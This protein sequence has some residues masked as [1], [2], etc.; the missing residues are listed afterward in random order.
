[1]VPTSENEVVCVTGNI[2]QLGNWNP[3]NVVSLQK[4]NV[5]EI[6]Y[7]DLW[8][9]ILDV[10]A[11]T[12]VQ[13]RFCVTAPLETA[14][15]EKKY[16]IKHWETNLNPR[17]AH[18]KENKDVQVM[19]TAMFGE[20]DGYN[21]G[22]QGWLSDQT[23]IQLRLENN[24]INMY[25]PR[26]RTQTYS[27]KLYNILLIL[28]TESNTSGFSNYCDFGEEDSNEGPL[29]CQLSEVLIS[30]LRDDMCV[31][32]KQNQFGEIYKQN[33]YMIFKSET[34]F[35]ESLGFQLEFYVHD[36]C[37]G[38]NVPRYIGYSHLLPNNC[39]HTLG[40]KR[41]PIMSLKHKPIGEITVNF[42]IAKPLEGVEFDMEHC[43]QSHWK[44]TESLDVG[45]RGMGSSYKKLA[46]VRENTVASLCA[47]AQNGADLVEFDIMLTKDL[48]PVIYHD[49][50]VQVIR[51]SDGQTSSHELL[52]I[53]V[54]DL[55]LRQLQSMK[56]L[57]FH[58]KYISF[59]ING[60][61][62]PDNL[63]PFP[64]LQQCFKGVDESLGFNI[65]IKYP[66]QDVEGVWEMTGF[67]DHNTYIDILLKDVFK[68]AGSRRIIFSSFDPDSCIL[69]Q[70]KQNKYPV[71]FLSN[72]PT[73]RYKPYMDIRAQGYDNAMY[74][75]L[76]EGFLGVDLQSEGLLQDLSIIK[77]VKDSGLILF[78]WGEDNNDKET[79]GLLKRHGVQGIIYDR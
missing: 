32:C 67:M 76:S 43:F 33:D 50:A 4:H 25:K 29:T 6:C 49:F 23:A 69:L 60:D 71:L 62:D 22:T 75:A 34:L 53:P 63:Q 16:L 10:P 57:I 59:N 36:N 48:F 56:V 37:D 66:L 9:I 24:P 55:T 26:H 8:W 72:G 52:P 1:M 3:E 35:P 30:V 65:E 14:D 64:T 42:M 54:K 70:R 21:Y 38:K 20:Y 15:G 12:E 68:G 18:V 39:N 77:R 11:N 51:P 74:F 47:A 44:H 31:P 27:I 79:I 41:L 78:V 61:V 58:F 2:P 40:N 7:S 73:Q 46:L 19:G 17:L 5:I 13:Y 28:Q 45:H